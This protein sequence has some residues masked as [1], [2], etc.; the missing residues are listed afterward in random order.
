M[1]TCP[2]AV[3]AQPG[4]LTRNASQLALAHVLTVTIG[5]T[6]NHLR[7]SM[8]WYGIDDLEGLLTMPAADIDT[9]QYVDPGP[10]AVPAAALAPARRNM[11]KA[12]QGLHAVYSHDLGAPIDVTTVTNDV[13]NQWRISGYDHTT[14][15]VP[16]AAP[17]PVP[18]AP[19]GA[20]ALTPAQNFQKG[21][22]KSADNYPVLRT[23][24]GWPG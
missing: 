16:Y 5:D 1:A 13:F 2:A 17:I 11:L 20:A 14:P 21:I 24:D 23:D 12:W 18:A 10:P 9:L 8:D 6:N 22:R 4:I 19:A 7:W 15:V 3:T